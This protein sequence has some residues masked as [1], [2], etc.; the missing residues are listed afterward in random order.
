MHLTAGHR[1]RPGPAAGDLG[2]LRTQRR[3]GAGARGPKAAFHTGL[4]SEPDQLTTAHPRD[5]SLTARRHRVRPGVSRRLQ[6]SAK[7]RATPPL[8]PDLLARPPA[9]LALEHQATCAGT[10]ERHRDRLKPTVILSP[11]R[12]ASLGHDLGQD[13]C[14]LPLRGV[15]QQ[16]AADEVRTPRW[17][18]SLLILV[19]GGLHSLN[20]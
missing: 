18:P 5:L 16:D 3:S 9:R 1:R 10:V 2:V 20:A 14:S 8:W 19:F 7:R 13:G 12:A 6:R 11:P 15:E 4:T 17:R